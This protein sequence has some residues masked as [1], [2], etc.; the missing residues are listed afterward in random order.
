MIIL[1]TTRVAH[2]VITPPVCVVRRRLFVDQ[3]L[4][5]LAERHVTSGPE[6]LLLGVLAV[7]LNDFLSEHFVEDLVF[8]T[9]FLAIRRG[10]AIERVTNDHELV[11][12]AQPEVHLLRRVIA[13]DMQPECAHESAAVNGDLLRRSVG[14]LPRRVDKHVLPRGAR[15]L[16]DEAAHDLV[17]V[18]NEDVREHL[19]GDVAKT[20]VDVAG[21]VARS[22]HG[23]PALNGRTRTERAAG[24]FGIRFLDE[25]CI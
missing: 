19:S 23:R 11:V 6:R 16:R 3:I 24:L 2:L 9:E 7:L 15:D 14:H 18:V 1:H 22:Q 21:H 4:H 20:G 17:A 10:E 8:R 25:V 13:E 5:E 12:V